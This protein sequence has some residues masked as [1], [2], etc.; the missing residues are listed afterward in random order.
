MISSN[1][2]HLVKSKDEI[3]QLAEAYSTHR[4]VK[5]QDLNDWSQNDIYQYYKF[6]L[7]RRV[8]PT[9]DLDQGIVDLQGLRDEVT[10]NS[11]SF[12]NQKVVFRSMRLKN[13]FLNT[14][15]IFIM[16]YDYK[17]FR[18]ILFG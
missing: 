10:S 5:S 17:P 1:E 7:D 2:S 3:L 12:F 18:K 11:L 15:E 6:C 14:Q 8:I 13:M 9:M 16:H 4:Q